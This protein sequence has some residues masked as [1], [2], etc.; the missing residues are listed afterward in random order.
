[1]YLEVG[2]EWIHMKVIEEALRI[3]RIYCKSILE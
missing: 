1:M 2:K 3:I